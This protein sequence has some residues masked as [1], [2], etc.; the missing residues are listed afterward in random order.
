MYTLVPTPDGWN[1]VELETGEI[2]DWFGDLAQAVETL[3]EQNEE[4]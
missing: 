4:L 2:V 3:N 1:L